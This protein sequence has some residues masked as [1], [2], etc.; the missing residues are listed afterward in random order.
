MFEEPQ[1]GTNT[2]QPIRFNELYQI[3]FSEFL[4]IN[5]VIGGLKTRN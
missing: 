2:A 3:G 4:I 5:A 1:A